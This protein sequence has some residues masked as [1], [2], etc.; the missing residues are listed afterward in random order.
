MW[1]SPESIREI[2]ALVNLI[3]TAQQQ[4]LPGRSTHT[5]RGDAHRALRTDSQVNPP[6]NYFKA[7]IARVAIAALVVAIS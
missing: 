5:R 2:K 3:E 6:A 7:A 1:G 4:Q